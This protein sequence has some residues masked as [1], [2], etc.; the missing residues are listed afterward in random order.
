MSNLTQEANRLQSL[1]YQ[2]IEVKG[3]A[4]IELNWA[5]WSKV[6]RSEPIRLSMTSTGFGLVLGP[7]SGIVAVDIDI[8][9]PE[10]IDTVLQIAPTNFGKFGRKGI[11]LFYAYSPHIE[12]RSIAKLLD[13]LSTGRQTVMPPSL[14]PETGLSYTYPKKFQKLADKE[15]LPELSF[16]AYNKILDLFSKISSK[17]NE[18]KTEFGRFNKIKSMLNAAAAKRADPKETAKE[19]VEYD[20]KNHLPPWFTDQ[21]PGNGQCKNKPDAIKKAIS[22]AFGCLKFAEKNNIVNEQELINLS[23]VEK[24]GFQFKKLPNPTGELSRIAELVQKRTGQGDFN[25]CY[26]AAIIIFGN[27][28]ARNYS[29]RDGSNYPITLNDFYMFII[30]TGF[31]KSI[32]LE[33]IRIFA[34][35]AISNKINLGMKLIPKPGSTQGMYSTLAE[36]THNICFYDEVSTILEDLKK[37]STKSIGELIISCW[38]CV[39]KGLI[40]PAYSKRAE[41][42]KEKE[43]KNDVSVSII[44]ATNPTSFE[45]TAQRSMI[46]SGFLNRFIII[47]GQKIDYDSDVNI[48]FDFVDLEIKKYVKEIYYKIPS[49]NYK[50]I[51]VDDE[52]LRKRIK[53]D[54][55]TD[56]RHDNPIFSRRTSHIQKLTLILAISD[57][58]D[59]TQITTEHY[60]RAIEIYDVL[61]HN[62]QSITDTIAK[63]VDVER[64]RDKIIA[65]VKEHGPLIFESHL[66]QKV[67]PRSRSFDQILKSLC[68][69]HILIRTTGKRSAHRYSYNPHCEIPDIEEKH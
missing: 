47:T 46:T 22:M 2:I 15:Y 37:E 44:A 41:L 40:H 5:K 20:L 26:V 39:N 16:D 42:E 29:S 43:C 30:P 55:Q 19:V 36:N 12:S 27:M 11:T 60:E 38:D 62:S 65:V 14:H 56:S 24:T 63:D 66:R 61:F 45:D 13:I 28:C 4:P 7:I 23:K 52:K 10:V 58:P 18:L 53:Q 32:L 1:G 51:K 54:L 17:E 59:N 31:G 6:E 21:A 67:N 68:D 34:K 33:A 3:K 69:G 9:S 49:E 35:E 8:D 64:D 57:C 48:D 50:I 25:L